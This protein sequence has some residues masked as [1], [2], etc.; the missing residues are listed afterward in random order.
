MQANFRPVLLRQA[1]HNIAVFDPSTRDMVE[2]PL[3]GR[4]RRTSRQNSLEGYQTCYPVKYE[5]PAIYKSMLTH[6]KVSPTSIEKVSHDQT[7]I[8]N[9]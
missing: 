8:F 9:G 4:T 3:F 6:Q 2:K 1:R 5:A 7:P